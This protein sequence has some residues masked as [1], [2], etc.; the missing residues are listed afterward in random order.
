MNSTKIRNHLGFS[1]EIFNDYHSINLLGI[2]LSLAIK[3]KS[4][5]QEVVF[6]FTPLFAFLN[7]HLPTLWIFLQPPFMIIYFI[8]AK[9]V[10]LSQLVM[11]EFSS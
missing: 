2:S 5:V 11:L 10:N 3:I 1:F 8:K 9:V 4:A 6:H 7:E